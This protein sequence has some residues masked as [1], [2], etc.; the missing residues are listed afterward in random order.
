MKLVERSSIYMVRKVIL[1]NWLEK[2]ILY[3]LKLILRRLRGF[4]KLT[5]ALGDRKEIGKMIFQ[6]ILRDMFFKVSNL[7]YVYA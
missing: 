5:W 3:G 2:V 1:S 6:I 7:H 4:E